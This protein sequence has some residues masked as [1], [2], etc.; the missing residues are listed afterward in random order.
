MSQTFASGGRL[1]D[2]YRGISNQALC[3]STSTMICLVTSAYL[4]IPEGIV[5]WHDGG[6]APVLF[7]AMNGRRH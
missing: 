4:F 6:D 7:S 3:S 2:P 1:V 5:G